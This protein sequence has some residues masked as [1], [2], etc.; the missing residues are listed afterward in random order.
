M[1]RRIKDVESTVKRWHS[2]MQNAGENYKMGIDSVQENPLDKAADAGDKWIQG[3]Q[4]GEA[5]RASK[6]RA[7]GFENW[8]RA[9]KDKGS[10][11]IGSGATASQGIYRAT[12]SRLLPHI[13]SVV[14]GLQP[15]GSFEQN[16]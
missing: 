10:L 7:Y 4:R 2:G 13:Q 12:M 8:K 3:C 1:A 16:L 6:L 15:R 11:R 5:K 9:A 14:D